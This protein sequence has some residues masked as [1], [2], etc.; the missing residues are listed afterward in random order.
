MPGWA[1]G[2]R[3]AGDRRVTADVAGALGVVHTLSAAVPDEADRGHGHGADDPQQPRAGRISHRP[4]D[5]IRLKR[6]LSNRLGILWGEIERH[7]GIRPR[8]LSPRSLVHY[9]KL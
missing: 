8:D 7:P 6:S 2:S 5:R 1:I 4:P 9:P 3:V